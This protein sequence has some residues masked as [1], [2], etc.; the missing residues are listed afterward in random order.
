M[1]RYT[2]KIIIKNKKKCQYVTISEGTVGSTWD[3]FDK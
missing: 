2:N 3:K 1:Y